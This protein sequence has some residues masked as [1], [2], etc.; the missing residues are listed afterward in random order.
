MIEFSSLL[1]TVSDLLAKQDIQ[2]Y[3][4]GGF[5]RDVLLGRDT[6]DIDIAIEADAVKIAPNIATA[7]GGK[8][9]LLNEI[10]KVSRVVLI[11]KE[12]R[13][14]KLDFSTVEGSIDQD[15]ARRDFTI[16]AMAINLKEIANQPHLPT[17]SP[18]KKTDKALPKPPVLIDPFHGWDDLHRKVIRVV[19]ESAFKA[20]AARLLR[21][22][23]L[24]AELDFVIDSETEALIQRYSH[25]AAGIAG[26]RV[27]EELLR[28]LAVPQA[29]QLL[30]YF[31]KLGLLTAVI[32]ELAQTK[33]V[34]QP[35]EHCWD[36]FEHSL[37]T[38]VTV[39]FLL[40]Q[41]IWEYTNEEVLAAAPWSA[42]LKTHFDL[43]ISSGSSRRLLLKLAALLHDVAKPQTKNIDTSGRMRFLGHGKEGAAIVTSILERLRFTNKEIRLVE[44]MVK[45]HL[46]PT[47]MSH[48][49]LPSRRA[50]YRY[51]RDTE[52]AGI[53]ILF[54]SLADHLATRGPL[55]N[56]AQWREHTQMTDYV[57]TQCFKQETVVA[58]PKLID[59]HD[60]INIY[61]IN[62]GPEI[63]KLLETVRE[64]QASGEITTRQE[65]LS[66]IE[67][68]SGS[69][70]DI[71]PIK[72]EE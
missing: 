42:V 16:N 59:G 56:L 49:E 35:K 36:V 12:A 29:E 55:L 58:P 15:L 25:L 22:V 54:L 44:F 1:T 30:P 14:W 21:A 71:F 6:A 26:E 40:R 38:V 28:L 24:A 43:E 33:Q 23:R 19:A 57:L 72:K 41:G 64:A 17:L 53:D 7:L 34:E 4:V 51:F 46:R 20:D 8:Y 47:Q 18:L 48:G 70:P 62:P 11:N 10:N 39:D 2:S 66:Y 50:I 37:K 32:P 13:Q 69:A 9:V 68:L 45:Y 3:V 31:D 63:G 61:G 60:L 52:K 67:R 5:V 27:R 65:A